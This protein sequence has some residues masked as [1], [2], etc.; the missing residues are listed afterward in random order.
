MLTL[1]ARTNVCKSIPVFLCVLHDEKS[2]TLV[3][4]LRVF[5]KWVGVEHTQKLQTVM[6]DKSAAERKALA[7]VFPHTDQI[8]CK[9]HALKAVDEQLKDPEYRLSDNTVYGKDVRRHLRLSFERALYSETREQYE[10]TVSAI[11]IVIWGMP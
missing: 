9:Y 7:I 2:E 6:L 8:L 3:K 1:Q 11:L 10:E 5:E 4:A